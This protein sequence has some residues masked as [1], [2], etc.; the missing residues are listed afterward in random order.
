MR[1]RLIESFGDRELIIRATRNVIRSFV[2]W[3]VLKES[4]PKGVYAL[5][6]SLDIAQVEVIAWLAEAFLHAHQSTTAD[7]RTVIDS[8][9]LF[10]FR[11]SPVSAD[12]L[13]T[14]SGRLDVL[15]HGLDQDLI[16]LRTPAC[17][18]PSA[19]DAQAGAPGASGESLPAS[20]GSGS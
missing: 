5:G 6:F 17:R 12:H 2:D 13:V 8:P 10:P 9:S 16:M 1:R 14:V 7:L 15:R 20:K 19:Y 11:L 4:S 18:N 3:Q